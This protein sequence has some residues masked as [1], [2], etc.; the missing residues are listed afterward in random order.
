MS[1]QLSE[2]LARGQGISLWR[3]IEGAL[4][5][6]ILHGG[7]APSGR[8]PA[9]P[10]LAKRFGVNRHTVRQAVKAL[11]SRGIL[12]IEQGRGT[13]VGHAP[14]EYPIG[15]QTRFSANLAGRERLPSR[16][17]LDIA[18]VEL[19]E[20]IALALSL[21]SASPALCHRTIAFADGVPVLLGATYL[22]LDRFGSTA[23]RLLS[24]NPS[25]T[26]LFAMVG[27]GDYR[28]GWTRITTRLPSAE[29]ERHLWQSGREP[30]LVTE[31]LDVTAAGAP[32]AFNDTVWAGE[33]IALT[34]ES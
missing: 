30:V 22:P 4:E 32:L 23:R 16:K 10:E 1:L 19:D 34:V 31:A 3:Q 12:R 17:T 7:F 29:E 13:F 28:R 9:E 20:R 26:A 25:M 2:G 27:H 5:Q 33:R 14:L 11:A 8:L 24:E 18:D 6:A 21:Q 15:R